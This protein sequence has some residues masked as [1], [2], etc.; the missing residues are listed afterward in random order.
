MRRR[1]DSLTR[2]TLVRQEHY[3]VIT[4]TLVEK[5][6]SENLDAMLAS[7]SFKPGK[8]DKAWSRTGTGAT[9][10]QIPP[11]VPGWSCNVDGSH[12][13]LGPHVEFKLID[14]GVAEFNETLAH[15]A[16]GYEADET[17]A[18]IHSEFEQRGI[19]VG[20]T[21]NQDMLRLVNQN[22]LQ[23]TDT[24]GKTT[25]K[26]KK[27]KKGRGIMLR[28]DSD[29][30][31]FY[32]VVENS[33]S[34]KKPESPDEP[35][36]NRAMTQTTSVQPGVIEKMYR[37]FWS[38]KGDVFHLLLSLAITLDDRVWPKNDERDVQMFISL[39]HH[40]TGVKMRAY[41]YSGN[42]AKSLKVMGRRYRS[43]RDGSESEEAVDY[44][45]YSLGSRVRVFYWARKFKMIMAVGIGLD[46]RAAARRVIARP[47]LTRASLVRSFARSLARQAHLKPWNS[48]TLASEA[49]VSPFFG[50]NRSPP[51][52]EL[53]VCISAAFPFRQE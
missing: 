32:V 47:A 12:L 16:G 19:P 27:K 6:R 17:L 7:K 1:P 11:A 3:P 51:H 25:K 13:P 45:G 21:A 2:A 39:V 10:C 38:R 18:A 40:V 41:F 31:K 33:V 28:K 20:A 36:L 24:L 53:P 9:G 15:A 30:D 37:S 26:K 4:D 29:E 8:D 50:P 42:E 14:Y 22:G 48:G 35:K 43:T 23:I 5:E 44:G 49:L 46:R 52:A 34:S